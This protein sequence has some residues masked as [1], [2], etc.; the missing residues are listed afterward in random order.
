MRW[1]MR[2]HKRSESSPTPNPSSA[3]TNNSGKAPRI[4]VMLSF[5][6]TFRFFATNKPRVT[7]LLRTVPFVNGTVAFFIIKKHKFFLT[8]FVYLAYTCCK[9]F[10]CYNHRQLAPV[11][12]WLGSLFYFPFFKIP[13]NFFNFRI[14]PQQQYIF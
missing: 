7:S 6:L 2:I 10:P 8:V 12:H 9:R 3:L 4:P 1:K 14:T 11:V 5:P 13:L